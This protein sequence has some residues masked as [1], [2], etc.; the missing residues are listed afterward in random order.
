MVVHVIIHD[1]LDLSRLNSN[2]AWNT[3]YL[4]FKV[5]QP[6]IKWGGV[7]WQCYC[8]LLA[9]RHG[10]HRY[11]ALVLVNIIVNTIITGLVILNV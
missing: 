1:V 4:G 2:R 10:Q 7:S 6:A 3:D 8:Q 11:Q 5:G 9:T